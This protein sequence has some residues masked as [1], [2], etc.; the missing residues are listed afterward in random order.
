MKPVRVCIALML[1][2][3]VT[4]GAA[5][6]S[7]SSLKVLKIS[8]DRPVTLQECIDYALSNHA[9]V[10]TAQQTVNSSQA[11]VKVAKSGFMPQ[12]SAN[13]DYSHQDIEAVPSV[14]SSRGVYQTT[15][16]TLGQSG[17][18]LS[19]TFWD[20]GKTQAAIREAKASAR[21]A[22]AGVD[23]A[24]QQRALAVTTAYFDALRTKRLADIATQTVEES[25]GQLKL[26]Q[27]KVGSGDAAN[28][29]VYPVEVQIANAKLAKLQADNTA[30]VSATALRNAVGLDR[31]PELKLVDVT[32]P[33]IKLTLVDDCISSSLQTR[34]ELTQS[35]AD[36]DSAKAGLS[37][38][39]LQ[40]LPIPTASAGFGQNLG[41]A[42]FNKKWSF[43]LG[44]SMNLFD[45]GASAAGIQSAKARLAT[46]ELNDEQLKKDIAAE[47]E[48]AYLNLTSAQ[49]QLAASK[50]N[51]ELAKTNLE[52]AR[53]KYT[54][55]LGIP[56][57]IVDAQVSY[58]DAQASYAKA[59]YDCY[60]ARAT[61]DIA[62]G[63][64]GY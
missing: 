3:V 5:L 60:I 39:K 64:R 43:G 51:V 47:V 23:L 56:L 24:K 10:L 54:Q 8:E 13:T 26:I 32:E 6:A 30:R 19:Q 22:D 45:G 15:H 53:E 20:G 55:G 18:G 25:A 61:L 57:E 46:R 2:L 21:A 28:V 58:A 34:P 35:T 9:S 41:G 38:A 42:D 33:S 40:A 1:V 36:L 17:L 4:C 12:I 31:G 52:V 49:E 27:A 50:P 48:S 62:M 11:G 29:D 59:L 63:K 37:L 16:T 7:E 44:L 14:P